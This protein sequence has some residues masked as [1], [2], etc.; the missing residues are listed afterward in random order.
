MSAR[1]SAGPRALTRR[2]QEDV[3]WGAGC[4]TA[5]SMCPTRIPQRHSP[6]SFGARSSPP[7]P[8]R[9][10]MIALH[11]ELGEISAE[12]GSE[13][14]HNAPEALAWQRGIPAAVVQATLAN[15]QGNRPPEGCRVTGRD[16]GGASGTK[17]RR[18]TL[19]RRLDLISCQLERVPNIDRRQIP[20]GSR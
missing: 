9:E 8:P 7:G 18:R 3:L 13:P 4:T 11:I 20:R 2:R 12:P 15:I 1:N 16:G 17:L 14:R 10:Y 6:S 5:V 19:S